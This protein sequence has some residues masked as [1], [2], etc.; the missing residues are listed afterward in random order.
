[1]VLQRQDYA[2]SKLTYFCIAFSLDQFKYDFEV[3]LR[4]N[5]LD[6]DVIA[7]RSVNHWALSKVRM[8][9]AS[10]RVQ[11]TFEIMSLQYWAGFKSKEANAKIEGQLAELEALLSVLARVIN[12]PLAGRNELCPCGSGKKYKKC[13]LG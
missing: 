7:S 11:A 13:C 9:L 5:K 2:L 12:K 1:M 3:L 4:Q 8:P 10:G 6:T